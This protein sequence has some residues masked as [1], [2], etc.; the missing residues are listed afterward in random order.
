MVYQ[1]LFHLLPAVLRMAK[2]SVRFHSLLFPCIPISQKQ[3]DYGLSA[4]FFG[5][6]LQKSTDTV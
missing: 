1:A 6:S 5:N 4:R 2:V 3:K